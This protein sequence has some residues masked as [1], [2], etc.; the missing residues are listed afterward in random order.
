MTIEDDA[1]YRPIRGRPQGTR[2]D[3][4]VNLPNV[5]ARRM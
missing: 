1:R 3:L 4:S 2:I 5:R